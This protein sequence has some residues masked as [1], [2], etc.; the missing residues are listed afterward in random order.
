MR[1]F[2][3]IMM[4][5]KYYQAK[6]W[7]KT[8][9]TYTFETGSQIEFFSADQ[10]DKLRGARRNRLFL[11]EANNLSFA[12]FEELEVRTDEFIFLDW[13]PTN[14]FWFYTEVLTKRH[15]VEHLI[16]T[17]KDNEALSLNIVRSIEQRINRK[18]WWQVYGLGLLGEVEGKVYKNWVIIDDLPVEARLER[19][20]VDF[21]YTND[22][23]AIVAVYR[24]N[25]G[26]IIDQIAFQKG[27]SNQEIAS[28]LK[29]S[30]YAMVVADS[31]EPKSIEEIRSHGIT[32]IGS[33]KGPGSVMHGIDFVQS[34]TIYVTKRSPDVI[35][36]YR[37]YM[38]ATDKDGKI[39]NEPEHEYSHSMDSIRYAL[40]TYMPKKEEKEFNYEQEA[41]KFIDA[42]QAQGRIDTG[43]EEYMRNA[44][45][46]WR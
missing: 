20:G 10:H 17:Y 21:G 11:N 42:A 38:F 33:H 24:W 29:N 25:G 19:Y 37:N 15:D 16:L 30:P 8:H 43:I 3:T 28:L 41:Q 44:S 4:G 14:E 32:I 12:A 46:L 40:A 23:T 22:P 18:G 45:L 34:Q 39:L 26:W 5:H 31:A 1:D 2:L 7:D 13:N 6:R 35:K 36:E 27:M 9:S